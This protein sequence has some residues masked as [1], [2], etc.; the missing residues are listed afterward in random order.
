MSKPTKEGDRN[1]VFQ[2]TKVRTTFKGDSSW[3]QRRKEAEAEAKAEEE[4]PWMAEVRAKRLNEA[5]T[6]TSPV[7]SP[8]SKAPA[9]SDT[10]QSTKAPTSGYLIRG[11]FTKTDTKPASSTSTN[12]F[13][14][15]TASFTKKPSEEYKKIAPH[16]VRVTTEP[17]VQSEPQL[18]PEEVEK[19]TEAASDV[20]KAN[21]GRQRS[22][23][24][25]AAKKYESTSTPET[26]PVSSTFVAKRVVISDD[27]DT[28]PAETPKE[29]VSTSPVPAP[30]TQASVETRVDKPITPVQKEVPPVAVT[31]VVTP[32]SVPQESVPEPYSPAKQSAG[33]LSALSDTLISFNTETTR[34]EERKEA[35]PVADYGSSSVKDSVDPEPIPE[36]S[37]DLHNDDLFTLAQ[38]GEEEPVDPAPRSP[39]SWSQDLLSGPEDSFVPPQKTTGALNLLADDVIPIDTSATSISTDYRFRN[40]DDSKEEPLVDTWRRHPYAEDTLDS[41][42]PQIA[43]P[44]TTSVIKNSSTDPFDPIPIETTSMKSPVELFDPLVLGSITSSADPVSPPSPKN[45]YNSLYDSLLD[46]TEQEG[47]SSDPESKKG[48]VL[49][50]EYV[51][52]TNESNQSSGLDSS[53]RSHLSDMSACSY[54]GELVGSDARI[55]IEH[56]NIS[57]HPSCFKCGICSREMGDLLCSMF[58]HNG[59]V[60]CESCYSNVI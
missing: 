23:V 59:T 8:V 41:S 24:L 14:G 6:E 17:T 19:R 16:T 51:D 15:P 29:P 22:Y 12:G 20:L 28:T 11:V 44:I 4:K 50:K 56:L 30:V 48:F 46:T 42:D 40:V 25:S 26:P 57:C 13:S 38:S 27:E 35:V 5:Q 49:L 52:E 47:T 31:P 10:T 7:S 54:C 36:Q 34:P 60:H 2:T 33:T 1:S 32:K 58:L 21:A 53:P 39:P 55:S 3:I 43:K 18:S 37:N 45:E 9:P